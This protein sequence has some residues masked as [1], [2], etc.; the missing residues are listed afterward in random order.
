MQ[1]RLTEEKE[2]HLIFAHRG[3][4]E[5]DLRMVLT[6]FTQRNNKFVNNLQKKSFVWV[7]NC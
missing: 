7:L 2:T 1:D 3:L 6:L 5:R 4:I